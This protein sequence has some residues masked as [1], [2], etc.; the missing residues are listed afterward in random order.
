ML[1]NH[2]IDDTTCKCL[3]ATL[4]LASS[5]SAAEAKEVQPY[6]RCL[7]DRVAAT[8]TGVAHGG[9]SAQCR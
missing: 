2:S 1:I 5:E 8:S 9:R 7:L 6:I 4:L 3:T